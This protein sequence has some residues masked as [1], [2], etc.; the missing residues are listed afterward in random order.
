MMSILNLHYKTKS[1]IQRVYSLFVTVTAHLITLSLSGVLN[2]RLPLI[3]LL[4]LLT[5]I[6]DCVLMLFADVSLL[7]FTFARHLLMFYYSAAMK[8]L[9]NVSILFISL[10]VKY[11]AIFSNSN[12]QVA[13]CSVMLLVH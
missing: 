10:D 12:N 6:L 5:S 11:S 8:C 3:G 2:T 9:L 13:H 7:V 1:G 4:S